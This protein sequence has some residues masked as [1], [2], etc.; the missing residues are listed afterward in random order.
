MEDIQE[1]GIKAM[2]DI[3]AVDT[4]MNHM[5]AIGGMLDMAEVVITGRILFLA[6]IEE[7]FSTGIQDIQG[8]AGR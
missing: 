5:E 1:A 2:E 7:V 3:L 8:E 4:E 6:V